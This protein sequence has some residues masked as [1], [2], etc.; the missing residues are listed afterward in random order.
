VPL[1]NSDDGV[2]AKS[3]EVGR[4]VEVGGREVG[5]RETFWGREKVEKT[6]NFG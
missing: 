6:N 3:S 5:R 2:S 1:L 4:R